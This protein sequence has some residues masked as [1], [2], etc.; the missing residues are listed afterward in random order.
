MDRRSHERLWVQVRCFVQLP[1]RPAR[2]VIVTTRNVSRGGVLICWPTIDGHP[3][4]QVGDIVRTDIPML[5]TPGLSRRY[6][7][8][9]GEVVRVCCGE[10]DEV[11]IALRFQRMR[12]KAAKMT[13]TAAAWS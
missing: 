6:L 8:C 5:T 11:L 12:V 13:L 3:V 9:T 1:G 2:R 7:E 4:P 10:D